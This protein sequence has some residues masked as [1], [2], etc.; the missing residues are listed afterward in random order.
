MMPV[1]QSTLD[2]YGYDREAVWNGCSDS[3]RA[4]QVQRGI[5]NAANQL[6]VSAQCRI[7]SSGGTY[8]V[9]FTLFN[10]RQARARHVA[11]HGTD[12]TKWPYNPRQKGS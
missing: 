10:K 6:G 12:R 3:D 2:Q 1:V 7:E 11:R 5:Y 8:R 9:V 4:L